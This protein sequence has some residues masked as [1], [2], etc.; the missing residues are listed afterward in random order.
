MS[1]I[2][3]V[4][5]GYLAQRVGYSV[6]GKFASQ[7]IL[8]GGQFGLGYTGGAYA[9][10]GLTNTVDPLRIHQ[11][12]KRPQSLNTRKLAYGYRRWSPYSRR[13]RY[14]RYRSRY[15]RR[16]SYYRRRYYY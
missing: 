1:W 14:H 6:I 5:G 10:Y 7:P 13:R 4:I 9:G 15:G 2:P 16:R 11:S 8:A 12:Y 3:S